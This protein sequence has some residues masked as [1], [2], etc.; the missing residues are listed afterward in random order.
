[1]KPDS[2]LLVGIDA[3]VIA[4][5]SAAICLASTHLTLM[6]VLVP[7]LILVRMGML[8]RVASREGVNLKAEV[9]FLLVCTVL[10]G[11]NDW[12]SVCNKKIYDYTVP[13]FFAFSTIPLWMLLFWGMIL[14]FVARLARW[15]AL[16]APEQVSDK[17]GAGSHTVDNA[18][19][20]VGGELL[21]VLVTR[22][23]IYR[24]YMDPVLSW[25]PFL[26]ALG[27]YWVLFR[28]DLHDGKLL[29]IFLAGGPLIEILYIQVG[30][31]HAYHLGWIGGV[32]LWIALWWLLIV[33]IW[34]DLAF[35]MERFLRKR[36]R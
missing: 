30:G 14:R 35:R 24:L 9:V 15:Q 20:K 36:I 10:G 25:L 5:V 7:A 29:L 12:N 28:P 21:L 2:N 23:T 18:A 6:T 34:K 16:G 17:L 22:Q 19:L 32:P 26:G 11:F 13:H 27:V 3:A 33:L 8:A 1:V 31:L 4:V